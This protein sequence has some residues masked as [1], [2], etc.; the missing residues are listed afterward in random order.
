MIFCNIHTHSVSSLTEDNRHLCIVNRIIRADQS[1]DEN[2]NS[3]CSIGIH[4][5]YITDEDY[6]WDLLL[7]EIECKNVVAL[8]EAGL[9]KLSAVDLSRQI[10]IFRKQAVLAQERNLPLIIHCVKAWDELLQVYKEIKPDNDWIIHGFRG[11]GIQAK[12][13]IR[14]GYKLSFGLYF[15]PEAVSAA[16]PD[17]LFTETDD[18]K[19]PIESVYNGLISSLTIPL[20]D[21][22]K[23][24]Y[25]N[26]TQ[27]FFR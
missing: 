10:C 21:F 6:Q 18:K 3:Y 22:G 26:V 15:N 17:N 14:T 2:V 16:W 13:L 11:N 12:Q 19:V 4:P 8:G 24:V 25:K 23:Q 27:T 7:Q 20:S 1:L 5:W 9:D